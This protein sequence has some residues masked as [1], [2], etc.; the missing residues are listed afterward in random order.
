M[1]AGTVNLVL[2]QGTT[3]K[4]TFYWR[5]ADGVTPIDLTGY[6]ARMQ[7]R[8]SYDATSFL[9]ELTTENGRISIT[10][11]TG[12]IDLTVTAADTASV[13]WDRGVYDLELIDGFEEVTRLV[14]GRVNV[15][16][17]VTR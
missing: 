7:I 2:E 10:P 9:L 12:R 4:H 14:Q 5:D 16:K 15:S 6:T 17:E 1:A 3:F 13:T 8:S 11:S